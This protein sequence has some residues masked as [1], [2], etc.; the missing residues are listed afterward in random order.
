M[1]ETTLP[2]WDKVRLDVNLSLQKFFTAQIKQAKKLDPSYARLWQEIADLS[3]AG[4]KRLRPY[5]TVLSYHGLGGRDYHS[6][7]PI[8]TAIELLHLSLLIHDDI[9]D[10]DELRYGRPNIYAK[11]KKYYKVQA[12]QLDQRE[13]KHYSSSAALIAGNIGLFAAQQILT[14]SKLSNEIRIKLHQLLN[15]AIFEV[16]GGELLDTE[17]SFVSSSLERAL[18]TAEY[19]TSSYSFILPLKAGAVVNSANRSE[20]TQ[21]H[22]LGTYLGVAYQLR[23][24][25][26][27]IF[28]DKSKLGKPVLSDL[29]EGKQTY[30]IMLI[31][32]K[33]QKTQREKIQQILS[34]EVEYSDIATLGDIFIKSGAQEEYLGEINKYMKNAEEI[35]DKINL[36]AAAK[37]SLKE[38][39]KKLSE[40][41]A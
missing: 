18:K 41:D 15:S 21:L 3:L 25:W 39:I 38:L 31:K 37:K 7:I 20:L 11:Y 28:G 32:K 1:R 16:M 10:R 4:G 14:T 17:A 8:A 33:S 27:G 12:P 5:L 9:I 22:K 30:L 26:L 24:D 13:V 40:R 23:D 6:I 34:S 2:S 19:K 29:R 36:D 35:L